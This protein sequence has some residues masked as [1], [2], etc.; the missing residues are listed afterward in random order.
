[1]DDIVK[2]KKYFNYQFWRTFQDKQ[3]FF[4][5]PKGNVNK[6]LFIE[7]LYRDIKDRKYYPSVPHC[8]IDVDKGNCVT[9][10]VPVFEIRDYCVYY[11]CIKKLKIKLPIIVLKTHLAGGLWVV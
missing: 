10:I 1:M 2:F 6:N 9:R 11:Y 8:Y 5:I 3:A 4:D 7:K